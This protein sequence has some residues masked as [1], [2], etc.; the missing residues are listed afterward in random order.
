VW[1][2]GRR[3]AGCL[4]SRTS[5]R[6]RRRAANFAGCQPDFLIQTGNPECLNGH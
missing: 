3:A 2:C 1:R 5:R 6:R 4:A